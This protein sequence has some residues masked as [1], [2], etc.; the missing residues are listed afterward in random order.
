MGAF[1]LRFNKAHVPAL[2]KRYSYSKENQRQGIC[3]ITLVDTVA[4]I[5]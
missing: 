3:I 5:T 2:A 1:T 4:L